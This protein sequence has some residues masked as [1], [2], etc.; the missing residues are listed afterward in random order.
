M[1]GPKLPYLCFPGGPVGLVVAAGGSEGREHEGELF[2]LSKPTSLHLPA[3]SLGEENA[4]FG[5]WVAEK[6][7][8]CVK[9]GYIKVQRI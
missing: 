2:G 1:H 4:E 8:P 5:D 9:L 3:M 6:R 7:E